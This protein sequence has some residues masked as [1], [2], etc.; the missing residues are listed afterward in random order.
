VNRNHGDIRV[1]GIECRTRRIDL[2][3]AD[4][5]AAVEDLAL[6]V[7][8]VDGVGIGQRQPA[9]ARRGQVER[10][11]AA[12]PARTDD[13]RARGAQLLLPLDADLGEQDVPAVPE[14]LLVV[15]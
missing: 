3:R 1:D 6:Q 4:R 11:R 12:E 13:Q 2:D 7:G 15:Q 5:I 14:E 8:E 10:R 9:D